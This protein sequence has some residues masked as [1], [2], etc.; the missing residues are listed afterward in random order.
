M[1]VTLFVLLDEIRTGAYKDLYHP[2][3]IL[4]GMEDAAGNFA[5]GYYTMGGKVVGT[6]IHAARKTVE[7]CDMFQGF[8][9][10]SSISGGT[11]SG[12]LSMFQ[13]HAALE[14]AGHKCMQFSIIPS[15]K[16]ST[17]PVEVY[18]AVHQLYRS[19][20]YSDIN[21]LM[22]NEALYDICANQ[23]SI[24]RPTYSSVNRALGPLLAGVTAS[25]RFK[26]HLN[27]HISEYL[28]NLIPFPSVHFPMLS[29][30]PYCTNAESERSKLNTDIL[31]RMV[32]KPSHRTVSANVENGVALATCLT[33][34]GNNDI[35]TVCT[36]LN[37]LRKEQ[38]FIVDW[39]P[40]GFKV[41]YTPQP[42]IS[43]PGMGPDKIHR[44]C[45]MMCNNTE[46]SNIFQRMCKTYTNLF[47]K[48]AFVH[49]Y[50]SCR[51]HFE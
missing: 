18:N 8:L 42:S 15:E 45:V 14:F 10:Y 16:L 48:K 24:L 2:D 41:A 22:D 47:S 46:I 20:D 44:S 9:T 26:S 21:C 43:I 3:N 6:L 33:Y 49:W 39:C 5:R 32:F 25:M 28:T 23:L 29:F 4:A 19:A 1:S 37:V 35:S 13:E 50:V 36:T 38:L 30:A 34:R 40:T 31:T 11:G 12:L 27:A 51:N 17:A 7:A